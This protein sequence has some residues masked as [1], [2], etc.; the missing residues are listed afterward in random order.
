MAVLRAVFG[1][2]NISLVIMSI[3]LLLFVL[4]FL[5]ITVVC[6]LASVAT[7]LENVYGCAAMSKGKVLAKGKK[8]VG[9]GIVFILY[10]ILVGL[11]VV[12]LLFVEYGDEVFKWALIWRVLIGVLCGILVMM[13]FLVFIVGQT[14][15]YLVCKSYHREA[16]DKRSLSTFLGAY[17]GETEGI[18]VGRSIGPVEQSYHYEAID[19]SRSEFIDVYGLCAYG[20]TVMYPRS[21]QDIQLEQWWWTM[22]GS[23]G[24]DCGGQWV[25]DISGGQWVVDISGG[26]GE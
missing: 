8:A 22:G 20:E 24:D 10:V 18:Q 3:I 14:V 15:L 17:T 13:V 2:T 6:Q 12:Y 11:I 19:I 26:S 4:G 9:M 25:V 7:V 16:I 21:G 5:Y 23:G 1:Y